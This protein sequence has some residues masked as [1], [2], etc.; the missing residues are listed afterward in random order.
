[1]VLEW[2]ECFTKDHGFPPIAA[3]LVMNTRLHST[4]PPWWFVTECLSYSK[5]S[6]TWLFLITKTMDP[7]IE[8]IKKRKHPSTQRDLNPRPLCHKG[9]ALV[10]CYNGY[11]YI[12]RGWKREKAQHTPGFKHQDSN[13]R[14][15][16]QALLI[17]W[18]MLC[19]NTTTM[20]FLAQNS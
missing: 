20:L 3:R 8:K 1:M 7:S 11:H 4:K 10:H 2:F 15:Q 19:A 18:R 6:I 14:I 5:T 13:T 9:R 12:F 16:T 17:M